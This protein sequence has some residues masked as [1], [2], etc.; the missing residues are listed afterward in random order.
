MKDVIKK[1]NEDGYVHVPIF[2]RDE[3]DKIRTRG[4]EGY[5]KE[6]QIGEIIYQQVQNLTQ[7]HILKTKCFIQLSVIKKLWTLSRHLY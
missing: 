3:I 5:M 2:S 6:T 1:W 4:L 7:I